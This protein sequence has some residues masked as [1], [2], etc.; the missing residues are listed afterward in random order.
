MGYIP[1]F[2]YTSNPNKECKMWHRL[3]D[4][5]RRRP[6]RVRKQTG[7]GVSAKSA[8]GKIDQVLA[9]AAEAY[10]LQEKKEEEQKQQ[11]DADV[12]EPS[13]DKKADDSANPPPSHSPSK[14]LEM[15]EVIVSP[16][17]LTTKIDLSSDP[18]KLIQSLEHRNEIKDEQSHEFLN[19][20]S[21]SIDRAQ[22][23]R[24]AGESE[25]KRRMMRT[26]MKDMGLMTCKDIS[27][28][29]KENKHLT[30]SQKIEFIQANMKETMGLR[31]WFLRTQASVDELKMYVAGTKQF[32]ETSRGQI[33]Q[34]VD[35]AISQ[36]NPADPD[37]P[38]LKAQL[39]KLIKENPDVVKKLGDP[40]AMKRTWG[41]FFGDMATKAVKGAVSMGGK[42]LYGVFQMMYYLIKY[43]FD[44]ILWIF[45]NP[46][47][48]YGTLVCLRMFKDYICGEIG[49]QLS[50]WG[51]EKT[52]AS[53]LGKAE[54]Q[55]LSDAQVRKRV[56][57]EIGDKYKHAI[58][59]RDDVHPLTTEQRDFFQAYRFG[60]NAPT[61]MTKLQFDKE[62]VFIHEKNKRNKS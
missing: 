47:T 45:K 27:D 53:A 28:F 30:P 17:V 5:S 23:K 9:D 2:C 39:D 14:D 13:E 48:A 26:L 46:T 16:S 50:E 41:Q 58:R 60:W 34:Y 12:K 29:L 21:R 11:A 35:S 40:A 24:I 44:T 57:A 51:K 52:K 15:E 62:V 33:M 19:K 25:E 7:G 56:K 49:R 3:S 31:N 37:C 55:L 32:L 22:Q 10:A 6:R 1:T 43:G 38:E 4:S 36:T 8:S 54:T 20:M 61:K 42:L 59:Y 18:E